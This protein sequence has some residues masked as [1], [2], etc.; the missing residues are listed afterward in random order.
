MAVVQK[1]KDTQ[2]FAEECWAELQKVTWPD[3]DQLRSATLV[4]IFFTIAVSA[5]IWFM[6]VV[7]D[8]GIRT[9]MGFFGA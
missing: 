7:S 6:D 8:W 9:I 4:V 5:V 1:V 2:V 3:S